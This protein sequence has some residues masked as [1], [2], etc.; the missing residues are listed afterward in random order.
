MLNDDSDVDPDYQADS[1][2]TD[3]S[4]EEIIDQLIVSPNFLEE[5]DHDN[6]DTQNPSTSKS[7]VP[8]GDGKKNKKSQKKRSKKRVKKSGKHLAKNGQFRVY[9]QPP[10]ENPEAITDED[11]DKSDNEAGHIN[12]LPRRL[13]QAPA[14]VRDEFDEQDDQDSIPERVEKSWSKQNPHKIGSNLQEPVASVLS[15]EDNDEVD[16]C[17]TAFDFYKLFQ[18]DEFVQEILDQ[19]KLYGQQ[20]GFNVSKINEDNFRCTEALLL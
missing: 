14:E 2:S 18:P 19:S 7:A 17:S 15:Q 6:T 5:S 12:H 13:L 11:S 1:D 16:S 9:I 10:K 4:D 8:S 20:R 3:S